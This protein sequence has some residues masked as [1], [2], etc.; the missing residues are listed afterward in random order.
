M[1]L[2]LLSILAPVF[3]CAAL[4]FGWA[5]SGRPYD[6]EFVTTLIMN[7][8]APCLIFSQLVSLRVERDVIAQM[9]LGAV[10]AIV[11]FTLI[12]TLVLRVMRLPRH[13]YL[14]PLV[15]CN[16]GNMGLALS[17]FTFGPEG[18]SLASV[19]FAVMSI[20]HFTVGVWIW[21]ERASLR[22][23]L[24]TPLSYTAVLAVLV[25]LTGFPVPEWIQNTT[26]LLG[27]LT[28][29][30]MLLTLGV[31]LS[32]MH[33]SRL[34]RAVGLSLLRLSMGF[35]IGVALSELL[36]FEGVARGVLILECSMPSAVFNYIFARRYQRSPDEVASL[37]LVSTLIALVV[38]PF[39]LA[40][41]L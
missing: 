6:Q 2:E 3:V 34:P 37:V 7:F 40:W 22:E 10:L 11:G 33:V 15:F 35:A 18:L 25:L 27:A 9:A 5:R 20:T 26:E 39:L 28:I 24:Q 8:G 12:G 23:L 17:L 21:S 16:A 36:G 14:G 31:S 1:I 4:G 38:L 32:R 30:L 13:T 41:L 29:P 19:F